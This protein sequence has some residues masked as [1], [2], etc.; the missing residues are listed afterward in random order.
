VIYIELFASRLSLAFQE[1]SKSFRKERNVEYIFFEA[2]QCVAT[3]G[4]G[5]EETL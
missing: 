3:M 2:L 4:G 5:L 1:N